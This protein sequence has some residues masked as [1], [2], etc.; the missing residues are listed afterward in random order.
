MKKRDIKD[1]VI[2]IFDNVNKIIKFTEGLTYE[3]FAKNDEKNLCCC[4]S[5]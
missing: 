5:A 3:D 2:D 1:Y 4:K